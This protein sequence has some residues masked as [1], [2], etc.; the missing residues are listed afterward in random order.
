MLK[1]SITRRLLLF[2]LMIGV[3]PVLVTSAL[4]SQAYE[5][6]MQQQP[7][8]VEYQVDLPDDQSQMSL[9]TTRSH[10]RQLVAMI[11]FIVLICV[12]GLAVAMGRSL[13]LPLRKLISA[14]DAMACGNLDV[15][16][17]T[18]LSDEIGT[19]A[20]GFNRMAR[21]LSR[22]LAEIEEQRLNLERRVS[23]RTAELHLLNTELQKSTEKVY[24]ANRLKNEFLANMSHELRTPL[25]AILGYADLLVDGVYGDLNERQIDSLARVKA[26]SQNLLALI[27]D[28]LDMS[29]LEAGRMRLYIENV[30]FNQ[31]VSE[32]LT[33]IKPLFERKKISIAVDLDEQIPILRTDRSKLQQILLNLISNA[34]KF[35]DEGEVRLK[36]YMLPNAKRLRI[37]VSDTG[38]GIPDDKLDAIF[39]PFRQIDGS[40]T[41]KYGGTGLGLSI[42]RKFAAFLEGEVWVTSKPDEGSKFSVEIPCNIEQDQADA[43]LKLAEQSKENRVVL[44]IDDDLDA[45]NLI[46][47]S[48]EREGYSVVGCTDGEEGIKRS[49]ELQPLAITLDIMMPYRDGWSVLREL[50]SNPKT[51]DIPVVVVS[52]IDDRSLGYSLG[53][54]DYMTKPI[55]SKMLVDKMRFILE[56]RLT[57]L[58]E[59][60][61]KHV[62]N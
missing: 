20:E 41:R 56:Q 51:E 26:N 3:L 13:V 46:R 40:T 57:E 59:G 43:K 19:L 14:A 32:M 5:Q 42:V 30:T 7:T 47:D 17:R 48:L 53:V 55:D 33:S 8:N 25:N 60:Q 11:S 27:N 23:E 18:T 31:L 21:E 12:I 15:R 61:H 38:I 9:E 37:E 36:A 10:I 4:V 1:S 34:L 28:I 29:K 49:K 35:T 54:A 62:A 44:A 58:S 52:I 16:I 2:L 24:K 45:L 22:A 6:L 50:K 39:D